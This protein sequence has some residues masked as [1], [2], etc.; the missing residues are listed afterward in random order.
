MKKI[1]YFLIIITIGILYNFIA[2]SQIYA[3]SPSDVNDID[4]IDHIEQNTAEYTVYFS[5]IKDVNKYVVRV[6]NIKDDKL[7]NK[8]VVKVKNAN[9]VSLRK[10]SFD[11][12]A[13]TQGLAYN[14]YVD[15]Y[16]DNSII[17]SK[18]VKFA[19]PL[20][21]VKKLVANASSD[22]EITLSWQAVKKASGYY[23]Y[24]SDKKNGKYKKI[25][26]VSGT[27]YCHKGVKVYQRQYY[28]V[29][30]YNKYTKAK[31]SKIVNAITSLSAINA[32]NIAHLSPS[33][34]WIS[35]EKNTSA[36]GYLVYRAID[37]KKNASL[38][39][40][41]IA[42]IKN[43]SFPIYIENNIKNGYYYS[44]KICAYT[45]VNGKN[46]YSPKI[47]KKAFVSKKNI[48]CSKMV[49]HRG[50]SLMAPENTEA[51]FLE[52]AKAG[53]FAIET[54]LK[55][56][57]DNVLVCSHD[58]NIERMTDGEGNLFKLTWKQL[59]QYHIDN[60]TNYELYPDQTI[61]KFET[62][63][64]ICKEYGCYAF[65]D[66]KYSS[67]NTVK[68]CVE[69]VKEKDM[70]GQAIF[71]SSMKSYLSTVHEVA[72][73]A[74][75]CYLVVSIDDTKIKTAKEYNCSIINSSIINPTAISL[76]HSKGLKIACWETNRPTVVERYQSWGLDYILSSNMSLKLEEK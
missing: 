37:K 66:L 65:I 35:W 8:K 3:S 58:D 39:Y 71:Q 10:V 51:A 63:L 40:K 56:T 52:A 55:Y 17:T 2:S 18:A 34:L 69:M 73:E 57:K 25:A 29:I 32:I 48:I 12:T 76:A 13:L 45:V 43:S 70:M 50:Y 41:K 28:K 15:A 74:V 68:K 67:I 72:P 60:G 59:T 24:N 11:I 47:A 5:T 26:K 36:D 20:A 1:K 14:V 30:P 4:L 31:S 27:T 22:T 23:I 7:V 38:T 9:K 16:C 44:Y 33:Q 49:A 53:A 42:T 46:K 61:C 19:R 62:Y 6:C 54:D 21:A 75:L 64:D